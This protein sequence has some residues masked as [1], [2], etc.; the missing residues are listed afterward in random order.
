M[1]VCIFLALL[2]SSVVTMAQDLNVMS[3]NIRLNIASDSMNAW[4]YR[5]DLVASQ[6]KFHDVHILGVQEALHMQMVDLEERLPGYRHVGGGRDD[7]KQKGEYC[8]IFYDTSR[9]AVQK[10]ETF[11]LSETPTVPGSKSWDAA[12]TRIVTWAKAKDKKTGKVFYI[13][14]THFDHIG[15]K[16][17]AESAKI[18]LQKVKD[19]AGDSPSIV[20]GDFN[21]D[22][23]DE[24]IKIITD[25]SNPLHLT[26]T[27]ELSETPHY[28]PD[29]TFTAFGPKEI[30][31]L[32]I[33]H[34]FVKGEWK[35]KKHASISQTWKGRY[36]S[37]HFA[38]LA[39]LTN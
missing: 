27:K 16:A 22:E 23:K 24:P 12:I 10:T 15:K 31:D 30:S 39:S 1:R 11:W 6:I 29:G 26:D 8:A 32:A 36:A 20:M 17:R 2:F 9:I 21:S 28:G 13:F 25:K 4:P 7:G 5:K 34:I 35:V 19:I 18:I 3:F 33:D 14:N 37:D 38:V